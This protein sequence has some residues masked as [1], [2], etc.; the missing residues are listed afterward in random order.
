MFLERKHEGL[1]LFLSIQVSLVIHGGY[2]PEKFRRANTK[3]DNLSLNQAKI[4]W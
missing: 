3:P 2:I 1:E 4:L